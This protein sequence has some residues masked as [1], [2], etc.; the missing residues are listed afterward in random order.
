MKVQYFGMLALLGILATGWLPFESA[1]AD[2]VGKVRA[3]YF[4]NSFMGNSMPMWHSLL[5]ASAGEEL[6]AK[7][8]IGPGW[9]IWM[10]L[11]S[12]RNR[13][14]EVKED[15]VEGNWDAVVIQHFGKPGLTDVVTEKFQ[16]KVKFDEPTDVGDIASAA[17][18]IRLFLS[19][20]PDEGRAFIYNSWPGIPGAG[21]VRD[22]VRDEMLKALIAQ[23]EDPEE[24]RKKVR[25]RKPNYEEMQ[26]IRKSFNYAAEW[27]AEYD[28]E[29]REHA[30]SRDYVTQLMEGLKAR[31]P[32]LWAEDRLAVIPM[33]EV[34]LAIDKKMRAGE[35]P[36]LTNIGEYSRDGGHVRSGLP[37]YTLG[38]T[39]FAVM[40]RHRP[41]DLDWSIYNDPENYKNE[42]LP[43]GYCHQPDLG[44]HVEITAE[45]AKAVNDAIWEVATSHPYTGLKPTR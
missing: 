1:R 41:H 17:E 6:E 42:N 8:S 20:H 18:I 10:H 43:W 27:L 9:Q 30:H 24:A 13:K 25:T 21:E 22:R 31:F 36:G 37:R 15:L 4:G 26:P 29:T 32:D 14:A 34:F 28:P 5:A 11:D 7:A 16:G 39:C 3:Y 40:F 38:A 35:V 33:G 23:G 2:E 12:F 44:V 45:R 19:R